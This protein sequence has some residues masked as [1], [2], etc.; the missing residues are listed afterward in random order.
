MKPI[1]II[2]IA[3][4]IILSISLIAVNSLYRAEKRERK[5][6]ENNLSAS[7]SEIRE[8]R[9]KNGELVS[10]ISGYELKIK[11][12]QKLM[13][14]LYNEIASLKVKLKNAQSITKI[15]TEY[16]YINK[17]SIVY[18][19]ISDSA[20]MFNI[21]NEWL[22]ARMTITNCSIIKPGDFI[23]ESIPNSIITAPEIIYKGWWFWKRP[24]GV[25]LH[26]KQSNPHC[27]TIDAIYIDLKK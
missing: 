19:S 3:A 11:E 22:K 17:D 27:S 9:T 10:I 5:R 14:Q 2:Q 25:D 24:I 12:V 26:I 6:A 4:V 21:D 23:I 8:Y 13:P 1:T 7:L 18:V 16:K 20:R 15:V